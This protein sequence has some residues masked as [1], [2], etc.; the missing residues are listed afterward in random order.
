[1]H[2]DQV[3]G[4]AAAGTP[5]WTASTIKLAMVADLLSREQAGALRLTAA[6]REQMAAMLRAVVGHDESGWVER[7][8]EAI[9]DG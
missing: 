6:D 8:C 4:N 2:P 3:C 5:I 9:R 7:F 1:M